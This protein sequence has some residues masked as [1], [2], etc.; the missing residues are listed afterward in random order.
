M[1]V[2]TRLTI[3]SLPRLSPMS[4]QDSPSP[5]DPASVPN[6]SGTAPVRTGVQ[7][8]LAI[9]AGYLFLALGVIAV[10]GLFEAQAPQK[11]TTTQLI[12]LGLT[13]L[14]LATAGGYITALLAPRNRSASP[15]LPENTAPTQQAPFKHG[16]GLMALAA[17]L[18]VLSAILGQN[19]E[20]W[21]FQCLNLAT[22]ILGIGTG[23]WL[24]QRQ[25][26]RRING[27]Q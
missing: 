18:W 11:V 13:Q 2:L 21:T 1:P 19:Q 16:L 5:F 6:R 10:M 24:R 23:A 26:N 15:T 17:S 4:A 9:A 27:I 25:L 22:A 8:G 3:S 14:V 12:A 20:P 7:S